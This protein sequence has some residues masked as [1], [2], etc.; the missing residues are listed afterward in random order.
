MVVEDTFYERAD[1]RD[2]RFRALVHQVTPT[3]PAFVAG[4]AT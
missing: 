4:L 2:A 3:N 1:N